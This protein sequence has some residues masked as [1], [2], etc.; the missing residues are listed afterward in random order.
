[1]DPAVAREAEAHPEKALYHFREGYD[2]HRQREGYPE[3]A[4][5]IG[6]HVAVVTG[7]RPRRVPAVLR[8][9]AVFGRSFMSELLRPGGHAVVLVAVVRVIVAVPV[10]LDPLVWVRL[11][12]TDADAKR[13]TLVL[14]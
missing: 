12:L 1:L 3:T 11:L 10:H 5:E 9:P 7:P 6:H 13:Y 14:V 2:R 8:A 4:P